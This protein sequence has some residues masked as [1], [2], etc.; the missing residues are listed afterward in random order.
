MQASLKGMTSQPPDSAQ[1]APSGIVGKFLDLVERVGNK[2][3]DPAMLFFLALV[4]TW[5]ASW[6]FAGAS[7]DTA[8]GP[9][10]VTDQLTGVALVAFLTGMVHTFMDFHPV[11]VVLVAM[12]GFGVAERTGFINAGLKLLLAITPV[13]LLTP[14]LAMV[15]IVSHTAVDAGYVLVIPIGGVLFYAAGRHPI[16][17]ICAAF[18]GVSG[19]FSANFIPSAIDAI[20]QGLTQSAAQVID[21]EYEVAV[22]CNW[23]FAAASSLVIVA[24]IWFLTDKIVEPRLN[25]RCAIDADAKVE[26]MEALTPAERRGFIAGTAA[27]VFMLGLLLWLCLPEDSLL[28]SPDGELGSFQAPLMQMIVPLIFLLALVP[29]LVHGLVAGTAKSSADVVGGMVD[30]MK[31]MGHYMVIMFFAAQFVYVFNASNL[32]AWLAISGADT[33]KGFGLP[34]P[35][36]IVG[37]IF[38]TASVNLLLGS[39]SA[40]WG[41]LSVILV[42][43]LM[44]LGI[45]PALTQAAYR[46][47]DSTTNIITPL[48]PYFPL[49]VVYCQRYVKSTGLGTLLSLMLPFSLTLLIGW[50]LFLILYWQLGIPLGIEG[51]YVYPRAG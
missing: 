23:Y 16:A 1:M 20:L 48:M 25:A 11:G 12:L 13:K 19:G 37:A 6:M 50:T 22:L 40:K 17:G 3:P 33:L 29:G 31:G 10:E 4:L 49:V 36:T 26:P 47:G 51:G 8:Q 18:A 44:Q 30:A 28:R 15:A 41:M 43:L 9:R 32:G 24:I 38:L 46:V 34:A 42:P 2:L 39:A 35:V 21:A 5:I 27:T 45:S 7:F 14:A